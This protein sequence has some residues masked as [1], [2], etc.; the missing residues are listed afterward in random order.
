MLP[1]TRPTT[2]L[3]RHRALWRPSRTRR[4]VAGLMVAAPAL[5]VA[6]EA[7]AA[8][9]FPIETAH[10]HVAFDV[11]SVG[12]GK[13]HG[14]FSS[15][16]G[17]LALDLEHPQRSGVD[18]TVAAASVTTGSEQL[19]GYIRDTFFDVAHF[20]TMSFQ[21]SAV[22]KLDARTAEVTG[23]L[24][25]HGVTHPI[26][27]RVAV[28]PAADGRKVLGFVATTTIHRSEFGMTTALPLVSDDIAIQVS[29]EAESAE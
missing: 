22:R 4:A 20:P 12:F 11:A 18:F 1:S 21:S 8:T 3:A 28:E 27:L 10:T 7:V 15:F 14:S 6:R 25:L 29:T 24:T 26:V 23:A 5:F 9:A 13:T 16:S 17:R 2:F 19:D